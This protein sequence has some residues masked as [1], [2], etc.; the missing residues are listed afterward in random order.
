MWDMDTLNNVD[1]NHLVI[2]CRTNQISF[3]NLI[4]WASDFRYQVTK[5]DFCGQTGVAFACI[6]TLVAIE[7]M[8]IKSMLVEQSVLSIYYRQGRTK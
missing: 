2:H 1:L 3:L 7:T 8:N 4:F 5:S 6:S